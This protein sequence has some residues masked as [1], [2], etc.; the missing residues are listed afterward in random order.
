MGKPYNLFTK[1]EIDKIAGGDVSQGNVQPNNAVVSPVSEAPKA[2]AQPD[3]APAVNQVQ[4]KP[5]VES[6]PAVQRRPIRSTEELA[7]AMGYTSPEEEARLRKASVTNQRIMAVADALR[8]IGNIANTVNYAPSQQF[9]QPWAEER[10]RYERGKALRD[11]ANYKYMSY[12][13]AKAAQ[14]AKMRQ[15]E[16]ELAYKREKDAAAAQATKDYR[17]ALLKDRADRWREQL[18]QKKEN[19]D[20]NYELKKNTDAWRKE[21]GQQRISISASKSGGGGRR[22]SSGG[23][24]GGSGGRGGTGG[25]NKLVTKVTDGNGRV[26]RTYTQYGDYKP[27][28]SGRGKVQTKNRL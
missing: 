26:V 4:S 25:R 16:A 9:N 23:R 11:A 20:R 5:V 13:Q 27:N 1:E 6:L 2:V 12:E 17:D 14:D 18:S 19:D 15:L 28:V 3:V 7:E 10:A 24:K 22:R 8:H 21:Q